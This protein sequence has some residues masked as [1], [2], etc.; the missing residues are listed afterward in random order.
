M[1]KCRMVQG[2]VVLDGNDGL[3]LFNLF[4]NEYMQR[5]HRKLYA[6]PKG[7]THLCPLLLYV[8]KKKSEISFSF[9][10]LLLFFTLRLGISKPKGLTQR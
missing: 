3:T 10:F 1:N 2:R 6:S 5:A 4:C 8:S 9:K 7:G